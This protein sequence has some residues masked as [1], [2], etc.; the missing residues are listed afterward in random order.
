LDVLG[1]V[2]QANGVNV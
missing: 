2:A 1:F